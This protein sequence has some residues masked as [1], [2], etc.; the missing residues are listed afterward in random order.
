MYLLAKCTKMPM[1]TQQS[2]PQ[3]SSHP[4]SYREASIADGRGTRERRH[5]HVEGVG[6][7]MMCAKG[8][9]AMDR[10]EEGGSGAVGARRE[11]GWRCAEGAAA[12]AVRTDGAGVAA[13]R[14]SGGGGSAYGGSSES[15][16]AYGGSKDGGTL[17]EKQQRTCR[18]IE[19]A[20]SPACGG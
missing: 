18:E 13:R 14:G 17:R 10:S 5:L 8:E 4:L 19:A 6:A 2:Y 7:A 15:N 16:D 3:L 11:K 20:T 12:E 9:V 1:S